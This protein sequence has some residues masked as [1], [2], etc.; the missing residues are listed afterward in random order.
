MGVIWGYMG[1][2]YTDMLPIVVE[3]I[4]TMLSCEHVCMYVYIYM[5]I[6]HVTPPPPDEVAQ[7]VES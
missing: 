7:D 1:G 6:C 3:Q 5:T 2:V 4:Y